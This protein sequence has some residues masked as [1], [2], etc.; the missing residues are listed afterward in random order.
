MT[1]AIISHQD[2]LQH[3]MGEFHPE[4]PARVTSI[5]QH[6]QTSEL[7][8]ELK[9]IDAIPIQRE[10]LAL[11]HDNHY[12]NTLFEKAE[13]LS[14]KESIQLDPDTSMN[15]SSLDAA[16]LAAGATIQAVDK[17]ISNEF[18][19]VFCVT[20]PPGHH[21]EPAKA[22]G[23]CLFNNIALAAAYSLQNKS[24]K[25]VAILDFDVHHG[26]GTEAI[27][28]G[29]KRV[30][31]CS[32][33]QSPFYPFSGTNP[34]DKNI[35]NTELA[36]HSDGKHL[37]AAVT[38]EWL[39]ALQQFAPEM[40]FISAGFDAH[41]DDAMSQLNFEEDDYYWVT[42]E[43]RRF[44]DSFCNGRIVSTLEG[45]YDLHSLSRSALA[46]VSALI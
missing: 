41:R 34:K 18:K 9:L 45:G 12:I 26:N 4:S 28:S 29:D 31:F 39:P 14:D 19:S 33:F 25:R 38:N 5:I 20:R 15:A 13:G 11:V 6:I 1:V 44:S 17:V 36:A 3:N 40:L 27:F 7:Y 30:L 43:L 35:I 16:L 8:P 37:R 21:A 23:F 2:C 32:T 10:L 22:M 42:S 24:L 46:H